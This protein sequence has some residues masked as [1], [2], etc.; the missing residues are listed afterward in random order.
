M[1][2]PNTPGLVAKLGQAMATPQWKQAAQPG[3]NHGESAEDTAAKTKPK[4]KCLRVNH[5]VRAAQASY[6]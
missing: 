6:T 4:P 2:S 5:M 1:Y 3:V